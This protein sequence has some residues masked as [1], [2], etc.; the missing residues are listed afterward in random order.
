M[1]NHFRTLFTPV[2]TSSFHETFY[3][4]FNPSLDEQITIKELEK[5]LLCKNDKAPGID[6]I[7]YESLVCQ[8][9]PRPLSKTK[10]IKGGKW[11]IE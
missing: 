4:D 8:G 11:G 2:V 10:C 1:E 7:P 6:G 9:V 5:V 3:G